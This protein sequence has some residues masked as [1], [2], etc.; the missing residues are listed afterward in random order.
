MEEYHIDGF[1]FDLMGIHDIE[2]M[3]AVR[4]VAD[5]TGEQILIYGEGWAAGGSPFPE[6]KRAVKRLTRSLNG[7]G[8][9]SDDIRDG[10]KGHWAD[11][12]DRG[13]VSGKR[14][15]EESLKFGIVG[16]CQHPEIDY[17]KVNY[18]GEPWALQPWQAINYVACHDDLCLLDKLKVS[19]IDANE[20]QL[21]KMHRLANAI[22]FTSQGIPFLHSGAELLRSK[23]G[24]HNSYKSGDGINQIDWNLKAAQTEHFDFYRG[25]IA[26]RK[27]H[28]AFRLGDAAKVAEYL[29]FGKADKD[30]FL[31]F[32]LK[33][34]AGGDDWAEINVYYNGNKGSVEVPVA[35]EGWKV[36]LFEDRVDE[37]GLFEV[38]GKN[39]NVPGKS[40]LII[41]KD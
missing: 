29:T 11:H 38:T 21:G 27:A 15:M 39:V 4:E 31:S 17:N 9:F 1:R 36:V 14:G 35:G 37:E 5:A 33:N 30:L 32:S 3:N 16:S 24:D 12:H 19:A 34:S 25:L 2:T 28:P 7:I 41:A 8:A 20:E 6:D 13:F 18:S 23:Q 22:V 26:L 40:T 10:I